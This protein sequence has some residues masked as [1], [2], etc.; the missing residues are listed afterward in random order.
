MNAIP[1]R[2][3]FIEFWR[4]AGH[5]AHG[6]LLTAG[7]LSLAIV[8]AGHLEGGRQGSPLLPLAMSEAAAQVAADGEFADQPM[9]DAPVDRIDQAAPA[10]SRE[11]TKVKAYVARRYRVSQVALEPLLAE[12][13][14][15]GGQL[16]L[17]PFLLVAMIAIESSFNPFA[18]STVGAQG[19]MQVIP[20]FHM[21][22]IGDDADESALFDP[23]LNIRVGALVLKEGLRRYGSM[24]SALQYYGGALQDPKAGYARKV[25]AMKARLKSAAGASNGNRTA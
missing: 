15:V 13:E 20:R 19:L 6:G 18:E 12:A 16:G 8:V 21:D 2:R 5:V 24:Q 23:R 3:R 11:M 1:A 9:A 7:L 14:A 25:L 4:F 22:K 17:D 10:L